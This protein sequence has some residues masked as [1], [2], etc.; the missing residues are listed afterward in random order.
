MKV[1]LC[2]S[3]LEKLLSGTKEERNYLAEELILRLKTNTRF[4]TSVNNLSALCLKNLSVYDKIRMEI[5][6]LCDEVFPFTVETLSLSLSLVHEMEISEKEALD[7]SYGILGNCNELLGCSENL[8]DQKL[9]RFV[10]LSLKS[11]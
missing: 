8:Q 7:L 6:Q 9:I 3:L 4:F 5:L 1:Y 2:I 10:R 11:K